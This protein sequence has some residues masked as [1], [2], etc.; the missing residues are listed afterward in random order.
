MTQDDWAKMMLYQIMS[1]HYQ[2]HALLDSLDRGGHLEKQ[3][4]EQDIA[5]GLRGQLPQLVQH[6]VVSW[7]AQIQRRHEIA[8]LEEL[9]RGSV[10]EG[11]SVSRGLDMLHGDASEPLDPPGVGLNRPDQKTLVSRQRSDCSIHHLVAVA[12]PKICEECPFRAEEARS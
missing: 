10:E 6:V 9:W 5:V 12:A 4:F 7:E 3:V 11:I 8:W 1:L 2:F